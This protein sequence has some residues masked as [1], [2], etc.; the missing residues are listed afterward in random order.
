MRLNGT[1]EVEKLLN[2]MFSAATA[3]RQCFGR[4]FHVFTRARN[5]R[6]G[7]VFAFLLLWLIRFF[8]VVPAAFNHPCRV[9]QMIISFGA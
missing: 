6:A 1:K 9:I 3:G 2:K 7:K 5:I 4:K 8:F